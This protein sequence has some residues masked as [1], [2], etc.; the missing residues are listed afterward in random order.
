MVLETAAAFI[1]DEGELE[2]ETPLYLEYIS[3]LVIFMM[4]D[5]K[6][7]FVVAFVSLA[8]LGSAHPC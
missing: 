6:G 5:F 3:R 1:A 2:Q 7:W 4:D 8:I